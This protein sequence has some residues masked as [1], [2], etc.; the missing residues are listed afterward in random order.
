MT[1]CWTDKGSLEAI[2]ALRLSSEQRIGNALGTA[3]HIFHAGLNDET[4]HESLLSHFD[5][6]K[7]VSSRRKKA[8]FANKEK[9]WSHKGQHAIKTRRRLGS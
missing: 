1:T 9:G 5:Y 8:A 6:E 4:N 7:A 3:H 2:A